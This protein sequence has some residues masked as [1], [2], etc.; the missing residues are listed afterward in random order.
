MSVSRT[1]AAGFAVIL[2]C[3]FAASGCLARKRVITRDGRAT[4]QSLQTAET[5]LLIDRVRR[6]SEAITS[7]NVTVDMVPALGS[8]DKGKITEYKDVRAYVLYRAPDRIRLIGLYPVVRS[9][10]FDMVSDGQRFRLFIP[11]KN[12]FVEGANEIIEPSTNKLENLRPQ[13]FLDAL[14]VRPVDTAKEKTLLIN[15][16][17]EAT[18]HYILTITGDGIAPLRQIWFDRITL[19]IDRQLIFDAKGDILTDARYSDWKVYDRV[20]FPAHVEINRPKDEYG[21]VM[22]VQKMDM[23]KPLGDEKFVLE[24]PEGATVRTLGR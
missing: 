12:T 4:G 24:R 2:L 7:I 14:I 1:T 6:Q 13:H 18:A 16:T 17:D 22:T 23:N 10:A 15:L 5:A 3:A 19:D 11:A 21:V 8:A 20:R 9:T